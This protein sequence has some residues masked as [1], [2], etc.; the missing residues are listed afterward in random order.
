LTVETAGEDPNV[1]RKAADRTEANPQ[2]LLTPG[3]IFEAQKATVQAG[4]LSSIMEARGGTGRKNG[5]KRTNR[6]FRGC[7]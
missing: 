7:G 4:G 5:I 2:R 3:K 6:P 1:S